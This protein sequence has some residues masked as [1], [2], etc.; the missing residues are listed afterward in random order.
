MFYLTS[1]FHDNRVNHFGFMEGGAFE[2]P[3]QAQELQ[4]SPGGIGLTPVY[5]QNLFHCRSTDCFL[6]DHENKLYLAKPR[7]DYLKCSSSYIMVFS[8]EMTFQRGGETLKLHPTLRGR[9][10]K[11]LSNRISTRQS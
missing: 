5:L 3:P 6:R 8:F 4:K 9:Y 1:K 10:I 2:A 7:T 11:L